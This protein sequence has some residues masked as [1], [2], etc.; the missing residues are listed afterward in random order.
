MF[1]PDV[2]NHLW[3]VDGNSDLSRSPASPWVLTPERVGPA[4]EFAFVLALLLHATRARASTNITSSWCAV[5]Q[6][7]TPAEKG[8]EKS[9]LYS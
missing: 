7:Q 9:A 8:D 1:C 4:E 6:R 3:V 2:P 5:T